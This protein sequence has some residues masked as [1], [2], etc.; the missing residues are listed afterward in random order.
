MADTARYNAAAALPT[1]TI[2][3]TPEPDGDHQ[4]HRPGE[5]RA[6]ALVWE[7]LPCNWVREHWLEHR[8]RFPEGPFA[9]STRG[10][11]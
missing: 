10:S 1:Q 11:T 6:G 3:E 2:T 4:V 5:G 7:D 8:R 9:R